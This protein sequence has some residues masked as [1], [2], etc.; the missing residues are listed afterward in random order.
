MVVSR[1]KARRLAFDEARINR[2]VAVAAAALFVIQ[3]YI[4]HNIMFASGWDSSIIVKAARYS[5]G[6]S[7]STTTWYYSFYPNNLLIIQLYGLL[8]KINVWGGLLNKPY[9][10]MCIIALNTL[11]NALS[12]PAE[13]QPLLLHI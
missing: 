7:K 3:L 1:P 6:Y 8:L 11:L 13:P 9:D 12:C 4:F 10:L 2:L 5:A